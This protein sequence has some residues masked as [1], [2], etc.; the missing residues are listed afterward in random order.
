MANATTRT[1]AHKRGNGNGGPLTAT[2]EEAPMG[3]E[4]V[5]AP[6]AVLPGMTVDDV[7]AEVEAQVRAAIDEAAGM[8]DT[9]V[10]EPLD[11]WDLFAV[12]PIQPITVNGPLLP[13]QVIKVGEPAFVATIVFLNPFLILQPGLSAS[14]VLSNFALPYE[15]RYQ[16]GNLT[17][18]SPGQADMNVTHSGAGLNLVPGQSF[19]VDVLQFQ[20]QIEGLY[21]MNVSARILGATPPFVNAPQFAGYATQVV[22]I[23]AKLFGPGPVVNSGQPVRFQIYP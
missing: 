7:R 15:V 16:T 6:E 18:W 1:R 10:A 3:T 19:Y 9:E 17:T 8:V 13:H 11:W 20:A 5:L 2:R 4:T 12:G 14:D 22:D 23:D 21:E